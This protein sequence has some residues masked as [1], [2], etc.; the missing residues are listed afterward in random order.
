MSLNSAQSNQD[1]L[2]VNET[3]PVTPDTDTESLTVPAEQESAPPVV[4]EAPA[5]LP[6]EE[7]AAAEVLAAEQP[8][9]E[10]P[11]AELPAEEAEADFDDVAGDVEVFEDASAEGEDEV[12]EEVEAP[13]P[14]GEERPASK[15]RRGDI[16][17]GT[18][19]AT[20]PMEIVVQLDEI[21]GIVS[22][23]ELARMDRQGLDELQVG[24]PILVYVLNPINRSGQAVLSLTRA[25]EERD[26][27][28]AQEY[29][30]SQDMYTG[31]VSGYNKG[32]LIVRFGRVRGFVPASQVREE[33]RVR[34]VGG[35]P[36]ER[37]AS[38]IGEDIFVKVVEVDRNRNRLILS[39]RAAAKEVRDQAKA[40]LLGQLKVGSVLK[41]RVVSLTDFG[42]FDD[43]AGAAGLVPL[44]ELSWKHVT[45]PQ[46]IVSVGQE[47]DVKIISLDHD[48]R[49]IGLSMKALEQDP[50][51]RVVSKFR[52][53]QLVRGKVT[54]LT[55]FGAF[56][57]LDDAPEIE[58]LVHISELSEHRVAHPREVVKEGDEL[59]LRIVKID[60]VQ[61]RMGL[62]LKQVDAVEYLEIDLATYDTVDQSP[63]VDAVQMGDESKPDKS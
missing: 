4:E 1:E 38:M 63:A 5:V 12:E 44:T 34:A 33:R 41:G 24:R 11:A 21:Q 2:P 46:E 35:S 54:K 31:K 56:A 42:A 28:Q 17:E 36:M 48:R 8:A 29:L 7:I 26:W 23:R 58:G 52:V 15:Y 3:G 18:V 10:A 50:W 60:R 25:L 13:A 51:D 53:G 45:K 43:L 39:E 49:R 9:V 6:V 40:D 57:C 55:K 32:G 30:E 59:T 37:W 62:S 14:V 19:V 20:S 16:V 27:R 47:V 61:R 22:G